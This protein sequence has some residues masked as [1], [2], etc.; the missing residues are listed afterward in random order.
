MVFL[1]SNVLLYLMSSNDRRA[2]SVESLIADGGT[3]SVQVLNEVA[4]VARRKMHLAWDDV[5]AILARFRTM[6]DVVPL[7]EQVH[8]HGLR[9][10]ERY[11]LSVYDGMILAAALDAGCDEVLSE[12]MHDGLRIDGKLTIRNPFRA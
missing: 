11:Q 1:D 5:N 2:D 12:D 9:L 4:H 6:L 10:A 7:T 8:M 3:I